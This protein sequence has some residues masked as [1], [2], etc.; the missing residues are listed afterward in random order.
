M[1]F[2]KTNCRALRILI[3][4]KDIKSGKLI[5]RQLNR[6]GYF[7]VLHIS[8]YRDLRMLTYYCPQR[9][10][11]VVT[12]VELL[13]ELAISPTSFFEENVLIRH[14]LVFD[15]KKDHAWSKTFFN[16]H[17]VRWMRLIS[18]FDFEQL[19][20]FLMLVDPAL[21]DSN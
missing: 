19:V 7:N 21:E 20:D 17:P 10:G 16:P 8:T 15:Q 11:M 1:F 6:L 14:L 2:E 4:D 9:L 12:N 5:E 13:E 3:A 18:K